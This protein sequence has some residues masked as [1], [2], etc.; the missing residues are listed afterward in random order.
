MIGTRRM[1]RLPGGLA[2]N[3]YTVEAARLVECAYDHWR[4]ERFEPWRAGELSFEPWE[5]V[6]GWEMEPFEWDNVQAMVATRPLR[7]PRSS[8]QTREA[9]FAAVI[10]S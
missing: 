5:P 8:A 7:E 1:I 2:I 9:D 3:P 4:P 10:A 6:A